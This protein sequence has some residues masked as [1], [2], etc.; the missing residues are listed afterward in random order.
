MEVG[1]RGV[2]KKDGAWWGKGDKRKKKKKGKGVELPV[3]H[4]GVG[5]KVSRVEASTA[6][7]AD[8]PRSVGAWWA[9]VV[10]RRRLKVRIADA[11]HERRPRS[12]AHYRCCAPMWSEPTAICRF[13]AVSPRQ[14]TRVVGWHRPGP[15]RPGAAISELDEVHLLGARSRGRTPDFPRHIG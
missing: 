6:P 11:S 3:S 10:S 8:L 1:E 4:L 13:K 5:A 15:P 7:D 14:F 9:P 2:G 12:D